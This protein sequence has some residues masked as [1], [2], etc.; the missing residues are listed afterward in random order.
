MPLCHWWQNIFPRNWACWTDVDRIVI[1][2]GVKSYEC[3]TIG[4]RFGVTSSF[5]LF[6]FGLTELSTILKVSHSRSLTANQ[7]LSA[8]LAQV[9]VVCAYTKYKV[10]KAL[11]ILRKQIGRFIA[12][13]TYRTETGK[14]VWVLIHFKF[15]ICKQ[16]SECFDV[17]R[18]H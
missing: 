16:C 5:I 3:F 11:Q 8:K 17:N 7:F 2:I 6:S 15:A 18:I 4:S 1:S 10:R 14:F 9:D 13:W 12:I